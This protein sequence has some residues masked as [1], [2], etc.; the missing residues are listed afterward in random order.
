MPLL[1]GVPPTTANI[2]QVGGIPQTGADW[3]SY[4]KKIPAGVSATYGNVTVGTTAT[5][6][7][8]ADNTRRSILIV[9]EGSVKIYIGSDDN[10]TTSNGLPIS[11]GG[12]V[13]I[14]HYTGK[15]YGISTQ[16]CDVRYFI[17]AD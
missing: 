9:N 15:I 12:C 6:I 2:V 8:S 5:S 11:S 14:D 10:V 4:F 7:A 1:V 17:E 13:V 16:D 3:T